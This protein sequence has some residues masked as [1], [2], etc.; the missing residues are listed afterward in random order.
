MEFY[1][2]VDQVVAL[3]QQRGRLSYRGLKRAFQLDDAFLEDLKHEL[4]TAQRL[5]VDEQGA[6]LVWA[7]NDVPHTPRAVDT[8]PADDASGAVDGLRARVPGE[9]RGGG[10]AEAERR[11]LTVLFCDLVGSTPLSGRLDPEDLR[12][13]VRA[14][15]ETAAEVIQR[16]AGHVAQFLGDGVLAYFGYPAAHEDDARRAVHTGLEIVDAIALLNIRLIEEQGVELAVRVGIHTGPVVVGAMGSGTRPEHMAIGETLNIAARLQEVAPANA[17]VIGASTTRLV[18]GA[19]VLDD[20]GALTLKGVAEPMTVSH[21]RGLVATA[22]RDEELVL[23]S[24]AGLVG[25]EEEAGLLRRRW[26]QT[27]TGLGQVVFVSGEAGIGKSALVDALRAHVRAEGSRRITF[28]CSPYHTAS[29]LHPVITHLERL[30][31]FAPDDDSATR[32]GKLEAGLRRSGLPPTDVSVFAALLAV[33]VPADRH[34]PL[35]GTPQQQ[36]QQTLDGLVA[37]LAAQAERQPVL[38]VWEDLH[39]SDPTTLEVLTLVIEQAPAVPMLHVL[40]SRPAFQLSWP[41]RSH[42]TSLVLNRLEPSEVEAL[43]AKRVGPKALP[44]EVLQHI[45]T[46]TDGVPLYVEELTKMLLASSLLREEADQYVLEGRLRAVAIPDTLQDALMAR[47]DQLPAPKEIAQLGAVLG[48]EFT[49]DLLQSIAPQDERTLRMGLGQ[50]VAAELLYQRGRP[51]HARYVFKHALIRDAAYAS[52]LKSTRQQIHRR[53]A[54]ALETQFP[55]MVATQPEVLAHHLT[56]AGHASDAIGYWQRAGERA[57]ARFA[58]L[59]AISHLTAGLAVLNAVPDSAERIHQ[60]LLLQTTLGPALMNTKGFAAPEVEHAYARAR[61]LCHGASD[62]PQLF[63]VLRGLWQF[64]NARGAYQTA[65]ELGEQC[66]ELAQQGQDSAR[67]LEGHH[68]IWTTRLLLGDLSVARTHLEHGLALYD[69]RQH[70]ALAMLHGHDPGV[71]CRGV[72]AVVLWLLGHPDQAAQHLHA[73][74]ALAQDVTHPPSLAFARMLTAISHLLRR[75]TQAAHEQAE[76]LIAL[77]TD[78]GFALFLAIGGILQG[79]TR[80]A[81]GEP[82]QVG[83]IRQGLRAVRETG[84]ALWEPYFLGLLAEVTAHEGEIETALST[85]DEALTVAQATG[86]RW[87]ES[88]LYRLRGTLLLERPETAPEAEASLQRAVDIARR[89]ESRSLELRAAVSLS[90]HWQQQGQR[91]KARAVLIEIRE[92]FSEGFDTADLREADALRAEIA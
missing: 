65:R 21:V 42:F 48:R 2:V 43:I 86:E 1:E 53:V 84:S 20:M 79:A 63:S 67:L 26:D 49:Y 46:K 75:E 18:L 5:A 83:Q 3:L 58:H 45:V 34:A 54:Q 15:Q 68:T 92:S 28:R 73:T 78:H 36:K 80:A 72:A 50:L 62:S 89:Q 9:T 10:P 23:A 22:S 29:A 16:Y 55:D 12:A 40:T 87:A 57:V 44:A 25:R 7:G 74:H 17:V 13:V 38:A 33:P 82:G 77:A 88:E 59:E 69:S 81:L 66:L 39:W 4:I 60:E 30:W 35:A 52:L 14:Y 8:I 91:Q 90:R 64:Y 24:A 11:Q 32:L 76:A 56:E 19:F 70:R 31:E 51:P 47:L 6:I 27:R 61:D 71:C 37:W 41:A 85:L